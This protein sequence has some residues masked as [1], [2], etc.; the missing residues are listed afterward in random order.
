MA[1]KRLI[2]HLG[3]TKTGTTSIQRTLFTNATLLEKNGFRYLTEWGESHKFYLEYLFSPNPAD[4][5]KKN[6]FFGLNISTEKILQNKVNEAI[7]TIQKIM[8]TTECETLIISGEYWWD[9]YIDATCIN[10]QNFLKKYFQSKGIETIIILFIRNPLT[11]IITELQNLIYSGRGLL[12]RRIDMYDTKI[13]G[14]KGIVNLKKYFPDYLKVLKFEDVINDKDGL[15]GCF[16]KNIGFP[17]DEIQNINMLKTNEARCMEVME[18]INY[19]ANIE[20]SI[21]F[22]KEQSM[23]K[24][25]HLDDF[26]PLAIIKGAKFDI[27]YQTKMELW[28]RFKKTI[29]LFKEKFDIDYSD[30]QIIPLPEQ[31][32]YSEETIQGFIEVF[33]KLN[34]IIQRLFLQFFENKYLETAQVKFKRLYFEDSIPWKLYVMPEEKVIHGN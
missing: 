6:K 30:Y 31:E 8:N 27:A 1:I 2:M 4:I 9:L 14:L 19:I 21:P 5:V 20:P 17:E 15:V 13:M 7:E 22:D 16:L 33:P 29:Q 25:R 26:K 10:I 34:H 24:N 23:N 28:E 12:N 32:I 11:W 18:L 3:I